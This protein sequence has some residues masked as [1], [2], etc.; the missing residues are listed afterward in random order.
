M[1]L[2]AL[3]GMG[4]R[5]QVSRILLQGRSFGAQPQ[6]ASG[7]PVTGAT[8]EAGAAGTAGATGAASGAWQQQQQQQPPPQPNFSAFQGKVVPVKIVRE[9]WSFLAQVA[10]PF[11]WLFIVYIVF[12]Y[13]ISTDK[14]GTSMFC[15]FKLHTLTFL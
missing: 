9:W 6:Q 3:E 1:Y 7:A 10:Y 12:R 4:M 2:E 5:D 14:D 15:T 8:S 11:Y 13:L